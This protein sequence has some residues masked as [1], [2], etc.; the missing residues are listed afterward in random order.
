VPI[1]LGWSS[2]LS[3][4]RMVMTRVRSSGGGSSDVSLARTTS[5]VP[6]SDMLKE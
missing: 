3:C 1:L 4:Q 6:S 2:W 5:G